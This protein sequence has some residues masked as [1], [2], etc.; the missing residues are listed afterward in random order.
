M[1]KPC[2]ENCAAGKVSW[3]IV[4]DIT[5]I[6]MFP[7]IMVDSC[8]NLFRKELILSCPIMRRFMLFILISFRKDC[9]SFSSL[10][11]EFI[12][13]ELGEAFPVVLRVAFNGILLFWVIISSPCQK[14]LNLQSLIILLKLPFKMPCPVLFV[15]NLTRNKSS[16]LFML[17]CWIIAKFSAVHFPCRCMF[18]F[19][20]FSDSL[21]PW[22]I[23]RDETATSIPLVLILF[24]NCIISLAIS[25]GVF[26]F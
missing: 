6:S 10:L 16:L 26:F 20:A 19:F 25:D 18:I 13:R 12:R 9:G 23:M 3:S 7:L 22:D 1:Q 5:S 21:S 4:S 15:C 14:H 24:A 17:V 8:S 11:F 2:N